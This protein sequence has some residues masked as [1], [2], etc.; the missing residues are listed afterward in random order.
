MVL[1]TINWGDISEFVSSVLNSKFI[2]NVLS[3]WPLAIVIII[4][5]LRGSIKKVIEEK[6]SSFKVGSVEFY[7]EKLL[8]TADEGLNREELKSQATEEG[9]NE[10]PFKLTDAIDDTFKEGSLIS[11][12]NTLVK[13]NVE[14]GINYGWKLVVTELNSL[15]IAA[16]YFSLDNDYRNTISFLRKENILSDDLV[17]AL[18]SLEKFYETARNIHGELGNV[19]EIFATQYFGRCLHAKRKLYILKEKVNRE[20]G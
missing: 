13:T 15:A 18:T 14:S 9:E 5:V 1:F 20:R 8:E 10:E 19:S 7:F 11:K 4:F 6:L 2:T 16:G 17:I 3:S 12:F